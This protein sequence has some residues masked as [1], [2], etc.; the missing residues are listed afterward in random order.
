LLKIKR[1]APFFY[2]VIKSNLHYSLDLK[3]HRLCHFSNF[4]QF[5][6]A[7]ARKKFNR[8]AV[9]PSGLFAGVDE[10]E[11]VALILMRVRKKLTQFDQLV[12]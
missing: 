1:F 12:F 5:A 6:K 8:A 4:F 11:A 2:V 9:F 3:S 7:A 10:P